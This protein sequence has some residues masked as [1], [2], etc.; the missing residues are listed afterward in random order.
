[1]TGSR[2]RMVAPALLF[3]LAVVLAGCRREADVP[4]GAVHAVDAGA[5]PS[6]PAADGSVA[7]EP[8]L[9]DDVMETD[10]RYIIGISYPPGINR[11]PEL[12]AELK[13]YADAARADLMEAVEAGGAASTGSA[14]GPYDLALP[15]DMLLETPR[16]VAVQATGSSYTGG[17]HGNPLV[18]RF[19]W[20]PDRKEMLRAETLVQGPEAW[21]DIS[22]FVR[23][24]L[25]AALSQRLD[26][27]GLEPDDRLRLMRS[28]GRMIDEGTAPTPDNFAHFEPVPDAGGRLRALRF[29]FPPYQVGPYSDGVQTVE[30]PAAVLLPQVAPE[31]RGLFTTG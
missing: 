10:P 16:I 17:A 25:H 7:E 8:L 6:A 4:G 15:F 11:Y 18:A 12:A 22:A 1:M 23:E 29:V 5:D 14:S 27:D 21:N 2:Y 24:S 30:V 19:V 13:R 28:G 20:L 26:A 9:L 3:A 31:Y